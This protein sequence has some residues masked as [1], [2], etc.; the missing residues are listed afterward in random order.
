MQ[1]ITSFFTYSEV[2]EYLNEAKKLYKIIDQK[3]EE[4]INIVVNE[5][6]IVYYKVKIKLLKDA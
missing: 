2:L 6:N 5:Y 4:S 1:V 3:Y